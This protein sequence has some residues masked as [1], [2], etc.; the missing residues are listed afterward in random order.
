MRRKWRRRSDTTMGAKPKQAAHGDERMECVEKKSGNFEGEKLHMRA[1]QGS[2]ATRP[3]MTRRGPT[4]RL[5][6]T[7]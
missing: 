1:E 4:F 6:T 2:C 7:R 3:G 5:R